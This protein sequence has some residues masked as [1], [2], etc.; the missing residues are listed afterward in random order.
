MTRLLIVLTSALLATSACRDRADTEHTRF[1]KAT[2]TAND[3]F[4]HTRNTFDTHARERLSRIDARIRELEARGETKGR[5]M[6][7]EL[8]AKRDE[9]AR[10]LAEIGRETKA[11][12]D[13]FE[14]DLSRRLD[15][16]ERELDARL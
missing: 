2:E 11:G 7:P 15:E 12:W 1:G 5:Q 10:E 16:I 9:A 6:L 14:S 4:A 13:R 3:D 8:R